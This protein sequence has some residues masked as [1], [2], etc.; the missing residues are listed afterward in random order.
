MVVLGRY[1]NSKR[2]KDELKNIKELRNSTSDRHSSASF[3]PESEIYVSRSPHDIEARHYHEK[4]RLG[5]NKISLY[6]TANF[7]S[8]ALSM[9]SEIEDSADDED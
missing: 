4:F 5:C 8:N 3:W 7:D 6:S 2:G 1:K 9:T